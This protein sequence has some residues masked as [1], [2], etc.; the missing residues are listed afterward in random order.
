MTS[1]LEGEQLYYHLVNPVYINLLLKVNTQAFIFYLKILYANINLIYVR[2]HQTNIDFKY[3]VKENLVDSRFFTFNNHRTFGNKRYNFS[4]PR[5]PL[6]DYMKILRRISKKINDYFILI[7]LFI[8]YYPVIGIAFFF[9]KLL[10]LNKKS[11]ASYWVKPKN[12]DFD[13]KYFESP[14]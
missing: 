4:C 10:S 9:F 14:Y 12:Q 3:K 7:V 1:V 13:K 11:S 5:I 8:F 6:P 2:K